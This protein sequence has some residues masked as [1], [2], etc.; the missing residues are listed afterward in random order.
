MLHTVAGSGVDAA[1]HA[2]NASV[3]QLTARL[4]LRF[5]VAG[6]RTRVRVLQQD[7]P[8]KIVRAFPCAGG[9]A[10][11]HLHNVSG[12]VLAGDCLSLD[13]DV[14]PRAR[15]QLTTTGATRLYRHQP[16]AKESEQTIT[17][18]V[19]EDGLLEYL[20]D[21]LI[22]FAGARHTQRI[23]I[24]LA[25]GATLFGWETLAPGRQ[26]MGEQFAFD[27]LRIESCVRADGRL[28]LSENIL[29]DPSRR[30]LP[31]TAR[32]GTHTHLA[33]FCALCA[34]ASESL[35]RDLEE[36]LNQVAAG[37]THS[38]AIW[39]TSTLA[40]DGVIARGLGGSGRNFRAALF[41]LWRTAKSRVTGEEAVPPRKVY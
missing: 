16:G 36:S 3:H 22:P 6:G 25:P 40:S 31:V 13:I 33:T 11:V 4:A 21:P 7:P 2:R 17:I 35:W 18:Q 37:N 8:W 27:R 9:G 29:L 39:G 15:V 41:E 12:G 38:G 14:A 1:R 10:L 23:Q 24:S 28:A 32:M 20:P 26:A 19:G 30:P 34:G 5:E